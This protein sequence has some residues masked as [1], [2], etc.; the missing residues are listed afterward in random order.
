MDV[1]ALRNWGIAVSAA[2]MLAALAVAAMGPEP[3]PAQALTPIEP[4][5]QVAQAEPGAPTPVGFIVRF[6]GN[7]PIARAQALAARGR[8]AQAGRQ[9]ADQL[10]RQGAFGGLCFDRFTVGGAEIVLRSCRVVAPSERAAFQTRW[11]ARL[12]AMPA[13]EY[14]DANTAV[15][16]DRAPG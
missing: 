7:G 15:A 3:M 12:N 14:A 11:L 4:F 9:V 1:N 16:Q 5:Y 8:E 10:E 13:V 6:R 2:L